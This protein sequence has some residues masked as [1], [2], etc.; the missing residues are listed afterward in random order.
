MS[1]RKILILL[2]FACSLY[3]Q[4]PENWQTAHQ[5]L[6]L[7]LENIQ[8][9]INEKWDGAANGTAFSQD[10]F[11][12]NSNRG[13]DLI[14]PS[15]Q[16]Q[17]YTSIDSTLAAFQAVGL[18]GVSI[19][20]QYPLLVRSFPHQSQYR[21]F[22]EKVAQKVHRRGFKLLVTC[23]ATFID[24]IFG[25]ANLSRDVEKWYSGL[26]RTRYL[27][28]KTQVLQTIIDGMQPEY[29]TVEMEPQ[30][31]EVNLKHLIN[32]CSDS[33]LVY[34]QHYLSRLQR[35]HTQIGAGAGT[36]DD[37]DYFTRLASQTNLD[38]I[39]LHIYPIHFN[40]FDDLVYKIDS[41]SQR[42][43]KQL[44]IG[45]AWCYKATN[46]EMMNIINPVA[47]SADIFSR[48]MFDYW[49]PVDTL[50]LKAV[51]GFS[52]LAHVQVTSFSW[53]TLMY[54]YL[55]Y[56]P[57]Q[58]ES[59]SPAERLHAG[60]QAGFHNLLNKS[61]S[62]TGEFLRTHINPP[63]A[64]V[65]KN[66]R[67]K[68]TFNLSQN[69]PNPF[70]PLTTFRYY[71]PQRLRVTISIHNVSGQWVRTLIDQE[72]DAGA[73]ELKFD[74]SNLASGTYFCCFAAGPVVETRKMILQR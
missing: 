51:I 8:T 47:S 65:T 21:T 22:Y 16:A 35:R 34:V 70:N 40:Y 50:F 49:V 73:H 44:V 7:Q 71:L 62:P 9:G 37:E 15:T 28:E 10:L 17:L 19:T 64:P 56:D 61:L 66:D 2:A 4:I 41:L 13:Y 23:Q 59:M 69:F 54:G 18:K 55:S 67:S 6:Q 42:Y 46:Q 12:A 74:A 30:T 60:Q 5:Q 52:H 11:L 43:H 32:Y 57:T 45:E 24:P 26:A 31:Q 3:A 39:D 14:N 36:W 53:P 25:E 38:Y 1:L 68:P 20:V 63:K 29:L 58:H 27:N 72:K 33:V 48:D